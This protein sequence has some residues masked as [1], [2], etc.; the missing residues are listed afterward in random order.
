MV[1]EAKE[2]FHF[3]RR[4]KHLE[5]NVSK[6]GVVR[7]YVRVSHGKRTRVHGEHGSPQFNANYFSILANALGNNSASQKTTPKHTRK[8]CDKRTALYRHYDEQGLLLYVGISHNVITRLEQHRDDSHWFSKI[9]N[10]TIVWFETRAEA[11]RAE[12]EAI[13]SELPLH[14]SVYMP[15]TKRAKRRK[16]GFAPA[17]VLRPRPI[18]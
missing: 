17:T 13:K 4:Y 5:R 1:D 15:K 3:V 7:W 8:P 18:L 14:N 11:E 16:V 2:N 6:N 10:V 9:A 12:R